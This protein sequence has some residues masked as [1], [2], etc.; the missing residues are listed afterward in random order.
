MI[1]KA[2]DIAQVVKNHSD[3]YEEEH[4][5]IVGRPNGSIETYSLSSEYDEPQ[6]PKGD[7]IEL[8]STTSRK[9]DWYYADFETMELEGIIFELEI[10]DIEHKF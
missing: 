9:E 8:E 3:K 1:F 4:L 7:F 2:K 6:Y 5:L 10:V